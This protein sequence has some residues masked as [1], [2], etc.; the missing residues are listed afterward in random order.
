MIAI[1]EDDVF[2]A[3][4]I[5]TKLALY[6]LLR[7]GFG[8]RHYIQCEPF[9]DP[10]GAHE[11]NRWLERQERDIRDICEL[12]FENG[13]AI[14]TTG[15]APRPM[16]RIRVAAISIPD[17]DASD[18]RLPIDVACRLLQTP[19]QL[20]VEDKVNDGAFVRAC[21][22]PELR[23]RLDNAEKQGW[24]KFDNGGGLSNILKRVREEGRD[25]LLALRLWVLFDSDA[26]VSFDSE[27]QAPKDDEIPSQYGPS[28]QSRDVV[29]AC[30]NARRV[31]YGHQ[32]WRRAIENYVP[33]RVLQ[34]WAKG[35]RERIRKVDAFL[36]QMNPEQRRYFN[37]KG[38]FDGD[39]KS[40]QGIAPIYGE[41][42]RSH[43]ALAE[44]FRKLADMYHE[45]DFTI[46]SVWFTDSQLDELEPVIQSIFERM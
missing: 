36:K 12:V 22:G 11:V 17:W 7:L 21:A 41:K 8:E 34:N 44:G 4:D 25:P 31:I 39:A 40:S 29:H 16:Q 15:F 33:G 23:K 18:P 46:E 26:R 32:L 27:K 24:V 10:G 20:V 3:S 5:D 42:L 38:G 30:K 19:L 35:D 14:E 6:E 45:R 28:Q 1:I 43:K 9:F 13:G 37:M 2:A